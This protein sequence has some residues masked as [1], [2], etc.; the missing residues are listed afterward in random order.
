M[1]LLGAVTRGGPRRRDSGETGAALQGS[2]AAAKPV[3]ERI[4]PPSEKMQSCAGKNCNY[5]QGLTSLELESRHHIKAK[6]KLLY[7]FI[8]K[9]RMLDKI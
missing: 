2:P 3:W 7:I 1:G 6:Y 9:D 8:R 5:V 4:W